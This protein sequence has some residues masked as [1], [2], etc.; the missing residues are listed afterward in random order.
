MGMVFH[1]RAK[2][3]L[4]SDAWSIVLS[5]VIAWFLIRSGILEDILSGGGFVWQS[6]VGGFFFTSLFTLAPAMAVLAE[7]ATSAPLYAVAFFAALGG[8]AGDLVL[9]KVF[10]KHL[11]QDVKLI[12]REVKWRIP[13]ITAATAVFHSLFFRFLTPL[14]G[15]FLLASPLPD[16]PALALMGLSRISIPRL[17]VV[18][19]ILH[20]I[21][22]LALAGVIRLF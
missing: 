9:F 19:F 6:L 22:I 17:I 11:L 1:T 21:G 12:L 16:E 14:F 7:L 18:S 15:A 4:E 20:F 2:K 10:R 5:F 3:R 13:V 8:I